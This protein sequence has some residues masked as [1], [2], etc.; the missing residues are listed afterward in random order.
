M[1]PS[2]IT[3]AMGGEGGEGCVCVC[4]RVRAVRECICVDW[5]S[6]ARDYCGRYQ[7]LDP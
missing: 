6:A 5:T 4:E 3:Y 2:K 1:L 7:D